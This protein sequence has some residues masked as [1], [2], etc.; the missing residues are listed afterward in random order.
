[1]N[2]RLQPFFQG[3]NV[4]YEESLLRTAFLLDKYPTDKLSRIPEMEIQFD[5]VGFLLENDNEFA[6]QAL[7]F[8]E[9]AP[10]W[11]ATAAA[12]IP[13]REING[14]AGGAGYQLPPTA[15]PNGQVPDPAPYDYDSALQQGMAARNGYVSRI[16]P[17]RNLNYG[18]VAAQRAQV[19]AAHGPDG[20]FERS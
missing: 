18:D 12:L 17:V 19:Q 7:R 1:M 13:L 3:P 20:G 16:A 6:Q 14:V 10:A 5:R 11:L 15:F 4:S 2:K 9:S 8:C